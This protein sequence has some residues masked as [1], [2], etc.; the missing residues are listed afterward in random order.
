MFILL[1]FMHFYAKKKQNYVIFDLVK[2][3]VNLNDIRSFLYIYEITIN[4]FKESH[5]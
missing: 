2:N 4:F 5:T 1:I 3:K